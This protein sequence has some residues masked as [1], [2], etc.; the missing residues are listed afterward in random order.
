MLRSQDV[1]LLV[2]V[3]A[4]R[5]IPIFKPGQCEGQATDKGEANVVHQELKLLPKTH[6][7]RH[8]YACAGLQPPPTPTHSHTH[9]NTRTHPPPS[10]AH[11]HIPTSSPPHPHPPTHPP[12][13]GVDVGVE[14]EAG[15]V[16]GLGEALA[17]GQLGHVEDQPPHA[18]EHL[19]LVGE[20]PCASMRGVSAKQLELVGEPA[21]S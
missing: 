1:G 21:C 2:E 16:G 6:N 7:A 14:A 18:P 3:T 17:V 13:I 4:H 19:E 12:G 15:A 8:T 9:P 20:P 5:S 11:T 10:S